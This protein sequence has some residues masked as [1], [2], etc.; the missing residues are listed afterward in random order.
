[1]SIELVAQ[2]SVPFSLD[3]TNEFRGIKVRTGALISGSTGWGEFAPF[4]EYGD[5]IAARWLAGALEAAFGKFPERVRASVPVNAIIPIL[6]RAETISAVESAVTNYGMTTFKLKVG[7]AAESLADDLERCKIVRT[8]L[9]ELGVVGKIRIDVN[10]SWSVAQALE[11]L[12][13]IVQ[14]VGELDYVEQPCTEIK[15]LL[16]LRNE[17]SNW[18]VPVQI[19]VD[20]SIRMSTQI[21]I[22]SLQEIADLVVIK[23][24]PLGGVQRSLDLINEIGLPTVISGSLDSSVG[25][26]SAIALAAAVPELYGACGLGTGTLFAQDL[27]TPTTVPSNGELPVRRSS[28]DAQLLAGA[29]GRVSQADRL[30]WQERIVRAWDSGAKDLVSDEVRE[31]VLA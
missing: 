4:P 28:P 13:Q 7:G 21:D 24:I 26:S 29:A 10:G 1:M 16:N 6:G 14:I 8:I 25:L 19:A 23:A 9:D 27:V 5:A 30:W 3:L 12:Q 18:S 20:E 2:Q 11:S 15:E 22:E 31:A 17:M